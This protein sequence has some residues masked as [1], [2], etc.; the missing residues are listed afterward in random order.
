MNAHS[1]QADSSRDESSLLPAPLSGLPPS[2]KERW[3]RE[4]QT[5]QPPAGE[6]PPPSLS[7]AR[8]SVVA[9][10]RRE[11]KPVC[12]AHAW[13]KW[14]KSSRG[15]RMGERARWGWEVGTEWAREGAFH[16][17]STSGLPE[18]RFH[19]FLLTSNLS[20]QY[21]GTFL[22]VG[23]MQSEGAPSCPPHSRRASPAAHLPTVSEP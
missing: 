15:A 17:H 16:C 7:R 14:E 4:G 3:N 20:R 9:P 18:P 19:C 8:P 21:L 22:H 13:E 12:S 2:V 6:G 1:G 23:G 11:E 10:C 5:L